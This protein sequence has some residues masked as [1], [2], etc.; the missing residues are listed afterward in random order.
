MKMV[1]NKIEEVIE[2]FIVEFKHKMKITFKNKDY[3]VSINFKN[4]Y[5]FFKKKPE[6]TDYKSEGAFTL[7][8]SPYRVGLFVIANFPKIS[9]F[10][11]FLKP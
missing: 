4:E 9:G 7:S 1:I 11:T 8:Q 5:I 10:L 6:E 2:V 3:R